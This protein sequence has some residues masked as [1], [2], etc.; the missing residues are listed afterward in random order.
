MKRRVSDPLQF[1]ENIVV[2]EDR[3]IELEDATAP[4]VYV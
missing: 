2:D 1:L 3:Q 4:C